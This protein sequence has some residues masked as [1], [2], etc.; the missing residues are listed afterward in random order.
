MPRLTID[1]SKIEHNARLVSDLVGTFG[2]RLV[3]VTKACLG[4]GDVAGAMLAGAGAES[5][6]IADSRLDNIKRVRRKLPELNEEEIELLRPPLEA[7]RLV[8]GLVYFVTGAGQANI[9]LSK[10][11]DRRRPMSLCL[12]VDT[13][14]GREGIPAG[15]AA[16]EAKSIAA[17]EGAHCTGIATNLACA[18]PSVPLKES[19]SLFGRIAGEVRGATIVSAGGSGLL[20]LLL[21]LPDAEAA[22]LFAPLTE[23]RCG[24]AILL[25]S[26]PSGEE[27][28]LFLPGAHRDAFVLEG[29]VLEVFRKGGRP[30]ALVDIGIQDIGAGS[31]TTLQERTKPLSSTSDYLVMELVDEPGGGTPPAAGDRISFIPDYYALLAA[32]TSPFV[33]KAYRR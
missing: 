25:G 29:A 6:A 12:Q 30:Q 4:D 27:P 22:S 31:I 15:Q 28:Q 16:A 10:R 7:G 21:E 23:L 33:E 19:L 8:P 5:S 14:D 3:A 17:L 32:M 13:G 24:E 26:I 1:L 9:L 20:R 18:N 11:P 2:L